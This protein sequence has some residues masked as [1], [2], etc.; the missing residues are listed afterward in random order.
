VNETLI[1]KMR[2]GRAN[3]ISSHMNNELIKNIGSIE[4]SNPN[5][6][7]NGGLSFINPQLNGQ[8]RTPNVIHTKPKIMNKY[9][10]KRLDQQATEALYDWR[11]NTTHSDGNFLQMQ[12]KLN[13]RA[14]DK[15]FN[16]P[17]YNYL[18]QPN[19]IDSNDHGNAG[20]IPSQLEFTS[21]DIGGIVQQ[22][23]TNLPIGNNFASYHENLE[24]GT[25]SINQDPETG[26]LGFGAIM[27]QQM[28]TNPLL[29]GNFTGSSMI[30][31]I[32]ESPQANTPYR[33]QYDNSINFGSV[34][35]DE[36]ITRYSGER[37]YMTNGDRQLAARKLAT[38]EEAQEKRNLQTVA[39]QS[40]NGIARAPR[41]NIANMSQGVNDD[42]QDTSLITA[43]YSTKYDVNK[44][45]RKAQYT[46]SDEGIIKEKYIS[47]DTLVGS[48]VLLPPRYGEQGPVNTGLYSSSNIINPAYPQSSFANRSDKVDRLMPVNPQSKVYTEQILDEIQ[49]NAYQEDV[50]RKLYEDN[51]PTLFQKTTIDGNTGN[52]NNNRIRTN[53]TFI[54]EQAKQQLDKKQLPFVS[55]I[56]EGFKSLFGVDVKQ[57]EQFETRTALTDEK[58]NANDFV[59][60]Q[61]IE[62]TKGDI[63][64]ILTM[65]KGEKTGF[66]IV[67][68]GRVRNIDGNFTDP[69]FL[70][71]AVIETKPVGILVTEKDIQ[72]FALV[73]N[74]D[75]IKIL[76]KIED[77][78]GTRYV[79]INVSKVQ[80]EQM[81]QHQVRTVD[82]TKQSNWNQLKNIKADVCDL[83]FNDYMIIKQMVEK[84]PGIM[85]LTSDTPLTE[86]HRQLL[87]EKNIPFFTN[88]RI[89]AQEDVM[90]KEFVNRESNLDASQRTRLNEQQQ[91]RL[92]K[93]PIGERYY[94]SEFNNQQV[95]NGTG[96]R[97]QTQPTVVSIAKNNTKVMKK[98]NDI[99]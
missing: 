1:D 17:M 61:H 84:I 8:I 15:V 58:I 50:K 86:Y 49:R 35:P 30:T 77:M 2:I 70:K 94:Q 41:Q 11:S 23:N 60:Q 57:P 5:Q 68:K 72:T 62:R 64:A 75:R 96:I 66:W 91:D 88:S 93:N 59:V 82:V 28:L 27:Q 48:S 19:R 85:K 47:R 44:D 38:S 65:S 14:K 7:V 92:M 95:Q 3:P 81:L 4:L 31:G 63:D 24:E 26:G 89:I 6:P 54:S 32:R 37:P 67:E 33:A 39:Y 9:E 40:L 42:Y 34:Y 22:F 99:M 71:Q 69:A 10:N 12:Q 97:D 43:N 53:E 56:I 21:T 98:F 51:G 83:T 45:G 79:S 73:K 46:D 36:R 16:K 90:K 13:N 74:G 55:K 18:T 76:Q 20:G 87:D 52:I 29:H 25:M 78:E 80:F